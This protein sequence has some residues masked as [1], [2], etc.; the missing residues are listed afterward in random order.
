MLINCP[1]CELQ[2]SDKAIACPHC[3]YPLKTTAY[4]PRKSSKRKRLP[5]GFGQITEIHGRNLRKP[6]RAM[7]TV[8]KT[9]EGRPIS[10]PLKPESY[11]E[12]YNDAYTA[13]AE[14]NRNPYD[15]KPALTV[16]QLY[17]Q[18]SESYFK[19]LKTDSS[20]RTIKSAWS[21]CS[22]IYSMRVCDVRARH[23]KG[24][25]T[26]GIIVVRGE[27]HHTTPN[28]QVR[29]KSM[30]NLMLDYAVEYELTDKNY[31]RTFDIPS[32]VIEEK[33]K[34][35]NA[36]IS[37]TD[38]EIRLIRQ[39]IG[40]VQYADLVFIQCMTGWRPQELGNIRLDRVDLENWIFR[41]GMKT[42]AGIDRLVPIHT[43]IR[44]L[45]KRYYDEAVAI[46]SKYLF[47]CT[48]SRT[49][50]SSNQLTYEK[51]ADRF[52]A[53]RDRLGL[54]PDHRPHDPRV[55]F[56]SMAKKYQMDEYALKY[57]VGHKIS[58]V[59]EKVYTEREVSWLCSEIEKI[60]VPD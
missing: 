21:Y 1:E 5:N 48:D 26:D 46:G 38:N 60:K 37:F 35:R 36:H 44:P 22:K 25:M 17:D 10:K 41:G 51:Y 40:T 50:R 2:V 57:I 43:S 19:T 47:N 33:E 29:I 6:F 45:V 31:A 24:C 11:F 58:D 13:L 15:L 32:D 55:Y 4:K 16:Q 9:P 28:I 30:F 56:T 27:E 52:E 49:H 42:A 39:N 59:T 3:G 23:I 14:Y 53:V 18:W 8:G 12:T 54:N 20:I 34:L 7:V